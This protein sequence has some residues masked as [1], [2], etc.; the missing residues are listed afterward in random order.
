MEKWEVEE[1]TNGGCR[2]KETSGLK[3][4][5]DIQTKKETT[6]TA[7]EA[8]SDETALGKLGLIELHL[9]LMGF[10]RFLSTVTNRFNLNTFT[11]T[12]KMYTA[13]FSLPSRTRLSRSLAL[14]HFAFDTST[15]PCSLLFFI[16]WFLY[17]KSHVFFSLPLFSSRHS[18]YCL[19]H[20]TK[21]RTAFFGCVPFQIISF[22]WKM[23]GIY[24]LLLLLLLLLVNC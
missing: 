10:E 4:K 14:L 22:L 8:A 23:N 11:H 24:A 7:T 13:T 21:S 18:I 3:I 15:Y 5:V 1:R 16:F 19:L 9:Q 6:A 12:L 20:W 17:M 2:R